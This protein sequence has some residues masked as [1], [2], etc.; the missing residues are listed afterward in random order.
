MNFGKDKDIE[1]HRK[2]ARDYYRANREKQLARL[3]QD[4]AVSRKLERMYGIT[5]AEKKAMY[6]AQGGRCALCDREVPFRGQNG[7][8]IDHN[9]ATGQV[10][11]LLCRLCNLAVAYVENATWLQRALEYLK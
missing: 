4:P 6:D 5:L 11:K 3:K 7:I 9:H 8:C 1:Y 2:R 10:R